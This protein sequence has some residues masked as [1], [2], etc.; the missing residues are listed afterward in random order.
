[1]PDYMKKLLTILLLLTLTTPVLAK[2]TDTPHWDGH[3]RVDRT[4]LKFNAPF[5]LL[6]MP[7]A[8]VEVPVHRIVTLN[9][10]VLYSPWKS[11]FGGNRF[12]MLQVS[13]EVRVYPWGAFRKLYV[14]FYTSYHRFKMTKWN[15]LNQG[16]YQDGN[17]LSAGFTVGFQVPFSERWSMDVYVSGGWQ[18]SWY[19]GY[20]TATGEQ[21]APSNKSGEWL[22]Y[23]AGIAFGYAL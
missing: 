13:P 15:Y 22:P 18:H 20:V 21:Y 23:K 5:W 1:M 19:R 12:Q 7:N 10:E 11:V 9:G 4:H 14:G 8:S 6:G 17:G 16:K 3:H 2:R